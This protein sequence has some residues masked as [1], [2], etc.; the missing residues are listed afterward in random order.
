MIETDLISADCPD[1]WARALARCRPF[2][3]Y[4]LP[5]Y[6][7]VA[8]GQGEGEP[9][10]FVFE[11]RGHYA[12]LPF[13][14]NAVAHV[15]GLNDSAHSDA[16]SVYGYPGVVTS[17]ERQDPGA[18][19]F[20]FR[21][22][23]ALRE[24]F[25]SLGVVSLFLRQNPLIDTSWLLWP[26]AEVKTLGPTVAMD[27]RRPEE[28]Q[29]RDFRKGHRY[30]VQAARK[31]GTV[32]YE[33]PIPE[34]LDVF[35]RIYTE[36]MQ[37][38][39]AEEY[40]YFSR[41]YLASLKHDL[42]DAVKLFLAE[43]DGKVIGGSLF[44]LCGN[45]I[46]YH[47]SGAATE[48]LKCRGGTKLILEEVRGWGVRNGYHWL[49]L[50]GGTGACEDSLFRF[51]SGFSKVRLPF[52]SARMVFRPQ[53]YHDLVR[54]REQWMNCKGYETPAGDYFPAYRQTPCAA[55]AA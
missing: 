21:F 35:W 6:Q 29:L 15:D 36:T 10:L 11:V 48:F 26:M 18:D 50:G 30:D 31:Q 52:Q 38:I 45:I 13:L 40:Y 2:D 41:Q 44:L 51:K 27:L 16:T 32:V 34:K 8:K 1:A 7:L 49:H 46:Q 54:L 42:A 28:D 17:A 55:P 19:A 24:A 43:Q 20:A 39:G 9:F 53:I 37:R 22:Q 5:G 4:H 12:A 23:A 25:D 33:A 47:L 14:L 3:S